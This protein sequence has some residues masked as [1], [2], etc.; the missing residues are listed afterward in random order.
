ML[1]LAF[2]E[3]RKNHHTRQSRNYWNT[4]ARTI[5]PS[6]RTGRYYHELLER[7]YRALIPPGLRVLEVGCGDGDLLA[8]VNPGLGVGIDFSGQKIA[9]AAQKHSHLSFV[10]A[11]AHAIPLHQHFDIILLSDLINDLW[12]VQAFF[13]ALKPL[14]HP[15]TRIILNFFNNLWRTPVAIARKAGRAAY[16]DAPNW[17]APHDVFNM[18]ELAD[19]QLVCHTPRIVLPVR[20]PGL[21]TLVNR[22]IGNLPLVNILSITN[23][24]V[25]RP[26]M[27]PETPPSVSII[28]PAKNE[29]GNIEAV[30]C[31][32][33]DLGCVT[34]LIF[35]EGGS[36]DNT[37]QAIEQ[38]MARH[39]E[40]TCHLIKQPGRGKADALHA[41]CAAASG[42]IIVTLDADLTVPPEYL[43][44]F[45]NALCSG[46]GEFVNGVRLV[47]PMEGQSMRFANMVANKL[48]GMLL[49]WLIGQPIKDTLCG[50]KALWK[51][52]Y[53]LLAAHGAGGNPVDPFGDFDLLLGAARLNLKIVDL[54]VRYGQRT[55]GASSINRWRHGWM[56]LKMAAVAAVRLKFL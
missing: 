34:E 51:T 25:A 55:Y 12:D 23:F 3:A 49:S 44:R 46:K 30:F 48:F 8:A 41:G 9:H 13:S 14:C 32:L 26:C 38:A 10:L 20:I 37:W 11:D 15:R 17:L 21:S 54:P 6:R 2:M 31:R 1:Q 27:T 35:V 40:T 16:A 47:Y 4:L 19:C 43:P 56:L 7:Y 28:I 22:F 5:G 24:A 42:S 18:L 53:D 52:D 33:P 36:A 29:A 45:V 39:P 50:T